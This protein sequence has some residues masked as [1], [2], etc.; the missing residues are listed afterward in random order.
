MKTYAQLIREI[1]RMVA[2]FEPSD[3]RYLLE[4]VLKEAA[5]QDRY[6]GSK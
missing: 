1:A 3:R 2:E 6:E 4:A 5:K